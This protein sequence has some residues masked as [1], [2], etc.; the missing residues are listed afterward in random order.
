MQK[1]LR[2]LLTFLL[3]PVVTMPISRWIITRV[4][5]RLTL[6]ESPASQTCSQ[7]FFC[8]DE[9]ISTNARI[10]DVLILPLTGLRK[11]EAWQIQYAVQG[12]RDVRQLRFTM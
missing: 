11:R 10:P 3:S 6:P 1:T 8:R 12:R 7:L 9:A 4:C 2:D 5:A